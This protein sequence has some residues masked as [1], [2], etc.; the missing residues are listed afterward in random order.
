MPRKTRR[1]YRHPLLTKG[2]QL[3]S[4]VATVKSPVPV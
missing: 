3:A 2:P 4:I 1:P